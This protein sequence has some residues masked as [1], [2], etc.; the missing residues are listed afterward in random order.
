[1]IIGAIFDFTDS[2]VFN[3]SYIQYF[4]FEL[5]LAFATYYLAIAGYLRS[6]TFEFEFSEAKDEEIEERKMLLSAKELEKLKSK[7]QNLMRDE[8]PC[9][10]PQ[11]TLTD[12]SRQLGVNSTVL[13]YAINSGF[14]KILTISST[15]FAS[16]QSKKN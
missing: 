9:L 14:G 10:E 16:P 4:Y 7:L 5:I 2:F 13:S 15:N 8:N 3:L 1:M 11:L 12:L 6:Q